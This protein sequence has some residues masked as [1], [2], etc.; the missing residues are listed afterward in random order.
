M[1]AEAF[2]LAAALLAVPT[3]LAAQDD[4]P[5]AGAL[6]ADRTVRRLER[7]ERHA[8]EAADAAEARL[9][10]LAADA[11]Q[12]E[13]EALTAERNLRRLQ[14]E[15]RRLEGEIGERQEGLVR[16]LAGLERMARRPV[17]A[18]LFAPENALDTARTAALLKS[19]KPQIEQKTRG[20]RGRLS[21]IEK[22][23]AAVRAESRRLQ[24]ARTELAATIAE[25]DKAGKSLSGA[26]ERAGGLA[27][28]ERQRAQALAAAAVSGGLLAAPAALPDEVR[29]QR[30]VRSYRPPA[31]EVARIGYAA[32]AVGKILG[33]FGA[34]TETGVVERGVT[35]AARAGSVVT[36]PASGLVAYAGPFRDYPGLVIVEHEDKMIT[37]LTGLAQ[38]DVREGQQVGRGA[39]L[40]R[41]GD[42]GR[43]YLELRRDG[44]PVDPMLYIDGA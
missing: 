21:R 31:A 11:Q 23:E 1:R 39:P 6:E 2:L 10:N 27:R 16:L 42:Q 36:A 12:F 8:R 9:R 3:A 24:Q 41:V 5:V 4:D 33:K 44:R 30:R 40:G 26:A 20:A 43:L 14:R 7:E 37:V 34:V 25:L 17:A 35:V 29:R 22:L 18:V 15:R 38:M 28:S 32:P 13:R 19:L